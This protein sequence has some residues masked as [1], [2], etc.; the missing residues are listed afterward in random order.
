[1]T[2]AEETNESGQIEIEL[3]RDRQEKTAAAAT[4]RVVPP[5]ERERKC[6]HIRGYRTTHAKVVAKLATDSASLVAHCIWL[7]LVRTL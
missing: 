1:M 6:S 4:K 5:V 2:K 3:H 7:L